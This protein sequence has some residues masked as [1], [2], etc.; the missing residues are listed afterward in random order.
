MGRNVM[1]LSRIGCRTDVCMALLKLTLCLS[2]RGN[3]LDINKYPENVVPA[4]I[5]PVGIKEYTFASYYYIYRAFLMNG[6]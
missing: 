6:L 3:L 5:I 2:I 1:R 4:G